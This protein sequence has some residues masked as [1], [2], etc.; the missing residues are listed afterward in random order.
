MKLSV[1]SPHIICYQLFCSSIRL[2][3]TLPTQPVLSFYLKCT[4]SPWPS[5]CLTID[6]LLKK[7][8]GLFRNDFNFLD[9]STTSHIF[10]RRIH[11]RKF[12]LGSWGNCRSNLFQEMQPL[13]NF[14]FPVFSQSPIVIVMF[15][16][17]NKNLRTWCL[18]N[19]FKGNCSWKDKNDDIKCIIGLTAF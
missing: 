13:I 17:F 3:A 11:C 16:H 1:F 4:F 18:H 2:G 9:C 14:T 12:E 6:Q 5:E 19:W 8:S 10:S 15:A 7:E